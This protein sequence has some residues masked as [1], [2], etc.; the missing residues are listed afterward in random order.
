MRNRNSV[1]TPSALPQEIERASKRDSATIL[2]SG[3][4]PKL[5]TDAP[6]ALVPTALRRSGG[7]ANTVS[8]W[9]MAPTSYVCVC[10]FI[11]DSGCWEWKGGWWTGWFS[12]GEFNLALRTTTIEKRIIA[13]ET[14]CELAEW[15]RFGRI[16]TIWMVTFQLSSLLAVSTY[17]H[18]AERDW[19]DDAPDSHKR[20]NFKDQYTKP[21]TYLADRFGGIT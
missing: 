17:Q 2:R 8:E 12:C 3:T 19:W 4:E 11:Y 14:L 5:I 15:H 21:A 13:Y 9:N 20:C 18:I 6:R 16:I 1:R 10:A 7:E